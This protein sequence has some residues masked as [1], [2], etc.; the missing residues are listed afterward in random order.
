MASWYRRF[1]ANFSTLAAPLTRLTKK[2]ARW[3]WGPDE[4]TAFRALKDTFMSAPVLACPDFS[5]RFFLQIDASASGL[6][7]VLTQYFEE[8]EQV[9]FAYA[10][11]TLNGA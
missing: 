3:A 5:R 10:S 9:A 7:A 1:I 11:R 4:D 8:G 6:G 2:N